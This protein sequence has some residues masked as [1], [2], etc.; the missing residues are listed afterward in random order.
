[1]ILGEGVQVMAGCVLQ[2]DAQIGANSIINTRAS[3][4]AAGAVVYRDV[5]E[6]GRLIPGR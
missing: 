2:T 5:P 3:V 4:V 1:V 6:A